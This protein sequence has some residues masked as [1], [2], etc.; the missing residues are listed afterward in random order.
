[1]TGSALFTL[2]VDGGAPIEVFVPA[3][4]SNKGL[5][6]LI[7]DINN[8]L[9]T[10]FADA[11]ADVSVEARR[12]GDRISLVRI[13]DVMR[14]RSMALGNVT[15][16]ITA[17]EQSATGMQLL[18]LEDAPTDGQVPGNSF[19]FDLT[20]DSGA[21]VTITVDTTD[22]ANLGHLVADLNDALEQAFQ[23]AG[24]RLVVTAQVVGD[25]VYLVRTDDT[26]GGR[27]AGARAQQRH[28]LQ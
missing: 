16:S 8:G 22:N 25:D 14:P 12:V 7:D 18:L 10:A 9:L 24:A 17:A 23:D 11:G 13:E 2:T 6:D 20:I 3:D 19:G 5:D 26:A 15:S 21:P 28:H 27:V 1:M 4:P